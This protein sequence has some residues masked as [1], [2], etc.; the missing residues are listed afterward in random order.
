MCSD[1]LLENYTLQG[2]YSRLFSYTIID[3]IALAYPLPGQP[4]NSFIDSVRSFVQV[5][6][7][8]WQ[9]QGIARSRS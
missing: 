7:S 8:Q 4:K 2:L 5:K 9:K 3:P 6:K 1:I